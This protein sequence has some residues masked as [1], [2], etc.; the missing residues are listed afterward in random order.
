MVPDEAGD[1]GMGPL[2]R[3]DGEDSR[4]GGNLAGER[5]RDGEVTIAV[6]TAVAVVTIAVVTV[7][8]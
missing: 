4:G 3:G 5:S 1:G 6:V 7:A 2:P 8:V